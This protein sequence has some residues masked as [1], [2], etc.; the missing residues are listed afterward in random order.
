[1]RKLVVALALVAVVVLGITYVYAQGPGYEGTGWGYEKWSSLTPEQRTKFQELRQKFNDET[2]QLRGT[3]LTKRLELQS[4]WADPKA[5]PKAIQ[6]KETELRSLQDQVRDKAAQ[7][8]LEARKVFTPEQLAQLG[9]RWGM[10]PGFGGGRMMGY[11]L[12]T[13]RG[14]GRGPAYGMS[15]GYG[16]CY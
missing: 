12:G 4:L 2:A 1:M 13:G 14:Y 5:D 10:G 3:I 6:T 16:M 15:Q 7:F 9:P 11:G 8:K